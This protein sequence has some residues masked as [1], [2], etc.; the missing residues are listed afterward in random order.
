M[1][2]LRMEMKPTTPNKVMATNPATRKLLVGGAGQSS[3]PS[4][5]LS[6]G[7]EPVGQASSTGGTRSPLACASTDEAMRAPSIR[8]IRRAP[9]AMP[10]ARFRFSTMKRSRAGR[11]S[12]MTG[13]APQRFIS[14]ST[15]TPIPLRIL[16]PHPLDA[17]VGPHVGSVHSSTRCQGY[18][19]ASPPPTPR[20]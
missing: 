16:V 9:P 13:L 11:P 5:S 10:V 2:I 6:Y 19:I 17:D 8:P 20:P 7:V 1:G 3:A 12:S 18:R 15:R 4:P 14:G